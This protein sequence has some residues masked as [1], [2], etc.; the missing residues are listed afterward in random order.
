MESLPPS[1][2]NVAVKKTPVTKG[3]AISVQVEQCGFVRKLAPCD[4]FLYEDRNGNE[5]FV[6]LEMERA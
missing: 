6:P 3:Q 2:R 1:W 4:G 5:I